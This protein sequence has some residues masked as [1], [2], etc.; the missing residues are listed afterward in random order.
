MLFSKLRKKLAVLKSLISATRLNDGRLI[1]TVRTTVHTIEKRLNS[2]QKTS[3]LEMIRVKYLIGIA[4]KRGLLSKEEI[5]WADRVLGSEPI[6]DIGCI[7]INTD[8]TK[9][10]FY[11]IIISR[12]SV[13]SWNDQHVTKDEL[14]NLANAARWAPSS[15]NRQPCNL[16]VTCNKNNIKFLSEVRKQKF[17][18]KAPC[19]ILVIMDTRAYSGNDE[20]YTLFLDAGATIQTLLLQAHANGLGACWVNF[21]DLEVNAEKRESV[22]KLF[23]IPSYMRIVSLVPIGRGL[24]QPSAPARKPVEE[25]LHEESI[26]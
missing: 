24:I 20:F 3:F 8:S 5:K 10:E 2:S 14:Y 19:C 15:C 22:M 17:I 9:N 21:G 25:L 18:T 13:R 26:R 6:N 4:K 16:I 11:N 7:P 23:N 1:S 12:R